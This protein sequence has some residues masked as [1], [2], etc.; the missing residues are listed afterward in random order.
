MF[1]RSQFSRNKEF[2]ASLQQDLSALCEAEQK[3]RLEATELTSEDRSAEADWLDQQEA[4]MGQL[5]AHQTGE[6]TK[7]QEKMAPIFQKIERLVL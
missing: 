5:V 6:D 4:S 7:F 1:F 2:V 3:L